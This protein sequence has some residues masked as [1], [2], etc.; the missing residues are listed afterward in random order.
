M[1]IR[2]KTTRAREWMY[3]ADQGV[4]VSDPFHAE[5]LDP[6]TARERIEQFVRDYPGW[7]FEEIDG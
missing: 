5:Q 2:A 7:E 3:V 4:L 6:D 1:I